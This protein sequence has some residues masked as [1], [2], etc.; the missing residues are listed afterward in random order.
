MISLSDSVK[1][2][3]EDSDMSDVFLTLHEML[4]STEVP[5]TLDT[6]QAAL[7]LGS[8]IHVHKEDKPMCSPTYQSERNQSAI[9]VL[10]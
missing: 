7:Q 3:V 8:P 5:F 4:V 1:E 10:A 2:Q 6:E 9:T